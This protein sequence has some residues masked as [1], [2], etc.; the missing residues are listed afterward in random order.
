[1]TSRTQSFGWAVP[2]LFVCLA[3]LAACSSDD[4]ANDATAGKSAGGTTNAGSA[5]SASGGAGTSA[6]GAPTAGS[7]SGGVSGSTSLGGGGSASGGAHGGTTSAG[8]GG[9]GGATGGVAAGGQSGAGGASGAAGA[10][11]GGSGGSGGSGSGGF[12]L[13]TPG[14]TAMAGCAADNKA[15]CPI[16]PK[17]NIG[18]MIG[19]SN[20]SPELDWTAGPSGTQS[21]AIV[22]HDLTN[23]MGSK[24]FVHWVIWNIP[25]ATRMLPAGLDTMA[26]PSVPAG[27]SQRSYAGNGYQGSGACGNVYEFVLY[28]LPTATI[29]PTGTGQAAVADALDATGAPTTTLRAR[30]GAPG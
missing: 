30:S 8:A 15:A 13:T 5:G 20:K 25:G 3:G 6:G 17:E 2:T 27:A 24:P 10:S 9:G 14:W 19:G 12:A 22:L 4:G 21:Y 23:L 28:A 16:F 1:M 29:T 11:A 7:A 18:T 26:M